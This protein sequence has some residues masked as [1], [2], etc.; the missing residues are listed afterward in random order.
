MSHVFWCVQPA[1]SNYKTLSRQKILKIMYDKKYTYPS[2]S[3]FIEARILDIRQIY[4]YNIIIYLY[5]DKKNLKKIV[6]TYDTRNKKK[7]YAQLTISKKSVG[8][9]CYTYLSCRIFNF[10]PEMYKIYLRTINSIGLVK[11][12]FKAYV[13][14]LNRDAVRILIED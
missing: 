8:Q 7:E 2:N 6:H 4:M 1:P 13:L 11:K 3:L 14:K 10:L 9:R 5:K 12:I